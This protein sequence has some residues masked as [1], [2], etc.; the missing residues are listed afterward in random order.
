MLEFWRKSI[1][2]LYK[3]VYA[4]PYLTKHKIKTSFMFNRMVPL[5]M[6]AIIM[7]LVQMGSLIPLD[8][9]RSR[10]YYRQGDAQMGWI[11]WVFV[12]L[13]RGTLGYLF[14]RK[15]VLLD[16]VSLVSYSFLKASASI[17]KWS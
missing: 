7:Q 8:A 3:Y 5:G 11:K 12:K 1:G 6:D 13:Y 9:L 15:P 10:Q 2:G 4:S 17:N 14:T 16:S